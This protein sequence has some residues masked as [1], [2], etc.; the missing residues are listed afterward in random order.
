MPLQNRYAIGERWILP[1]G[2]CIFV[3]EQPGGLMLFRLE[4]TQ[5]NG[6]VQH[7]VKAEAE[8]DRL[9][10]TRRA[11]RDRQ[12]RDA[13]GRLQRSNDAGDV[14]PEGASDKART[15]QFYT[16]MWDE[17]PCGTGEVALQRLI[18]FHTPEAKRRGL[19]WQP[20]PSTLKRAIGQRGE[21]GLRPIRV[22]QDM[23][24][25]TPR[26]R[27]APVIEQV[28]KRTVAWYYAMNTR[29]ALK[30]HARIVRFVGHVNGIGRARY[31]DGWKTLPTPSD[32]TVRRYIRDAASLETC[33]AKWGMTEA[34]RRFQGIRRGLEAK[35]ILDVVLIDG[36]VVDGWC[37]LDD[38][39]HTP[40]G[41]PTLTLAIDL[42]S[43]AVLGVI[44]TYEGESL[45]AIMACL[46]QVITGK[47]DII[48]RLPQFRDL[49]EGLYGK[50]DTI[51]VDNAW[52]Q[53]GVSFQD[54]CED[55]NIN[56]E[57]APVKNPEYK[58]FVERFFRTLNEILFKEMPGGVPF[59]PVMMR[60]LGLDPRKT[61]AITLSR[62]EEFI[63]TAIYEVYGQEPHSGIGMAPLLAWRK[64]LAAAPREIVDDIDFLAAAFGM[65]DEAT[66]DRTG[67]TF[68]NLKFHDPDVTTALLNDLASTT[69][70]RRQRKRLS[71]ATARVKIKYNPA[72]I[73]GIWVWNPKMTPKRGY[74]FLPNW[75]S[76][77]AATPVLGFWH[78]QQVL[79]FA[80][81]ENLAFRSD[82]DKC[83]ARDRLRASLEA[84]APDLR[85]AAMRTQRR[86]L[87]PSPPVLSGDTVQRTQGTPSV[88]GL[89]TNDVTVSIA[90]QERDDE[91]YPEK[92]PRR[93]GAKAAK[94]AARARAAKGTNGDGG[95]TPAG[96]P[97][98]DP[99]AP[100]DLMVEDPDVYM[101]ALAERLAQRR[102]AKDG[103]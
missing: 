4:S 43:R 65:V 38:R 32:E 75:D 84:A 5:P 9:R 46:Q 6:E 77:Y 72:D 89:Q 63:Y 60:K 11:R 59:D 34:R 93:G 19:L 69:P 29:T 81:A 20:S 50:P 31:G 97:A 87:E 92:G 70:V 13:T 41:R 99:F 14:L 3:Q 36:T 95:T 66:L 68:R 23:R 24:A 18:N 7:F 76:E 52:R 51:V 53:T 94:A 25:Q 90:A 62:L 39:T 86:L 15:L 42:K 47:H 67:I 33:A 37:V 101:A 79:A 12:F 88:S 28:L 102:A 85:F 1:E 58:A 40:A 73:R 74:V 71:S 21:P 48:E 16:R 55:G 30:A 26:R 54:A 8:L 78:H 57:W 83:L 64:G 44:I 61:A 45:F 35:Q 22:M 91:G 98:A 27:W 56:V 82:V 17:A 80:K 96:T 100:Q 2:A 103:D 49:L 10:D